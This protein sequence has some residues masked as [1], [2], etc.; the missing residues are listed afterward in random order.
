M[1][2][3]VVPARWATMSRARHFGVAGA[4]RSS[5][6]S[7]AGPDHLDDAEPG[8]PVDGG[9]VDVGHA[10]N[11][12]AH[13]TIAVEV[14]HRFGT[15]SIHGGET[16]P[17]SVTPTV[18]R[19]RWRASGVRTRAGLRTSDK[20]QPMSGSKARLQAIEHVKAHESPA[21]FFSA[22]DAPG[23]IF[24]QNV[25]SKAVM[26][27]R[28]PKPVYKSVMATI[29][30]SKP[31]DPTIADI[32]ASAMKD[33]AI[34][35][36]ATHYAHVFYPLTGLDGREARQLPRARRRGRRRDRRVRRQDADPGRAR[37]LELPERRPP[38]HVRGPR[39][40]RLGRHQPGLHP[41]EPERDHALHPHG[42]RL[43]DRRGA[44]QEDAAAALAAGAE[45]AGPAR[46]EAV[47][48]QRPRRRRVA[49]PAPSR[50][51]S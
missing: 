26:Q 29:E 9:V 48:P 24:G 30:H 27:K 23:E 37:R 38:R 25:F 18:P 4:G 46:P 2:S 28:L 47:R 50:S 10:G 51:T 13:R 32:V 20:E 12:T 39:L 35:K 16:F 33:W 6:S 22:D 17:T 8:I 11:L 45:Q 5:A 31:L 1:A 19:G 40:H 43:V 21:T 44:R 3:A 41:R 36:G 42:V 14:G 49:S 15:R 7:G 34:E